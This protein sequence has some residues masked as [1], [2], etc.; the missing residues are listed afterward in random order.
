M[1]RYEK[2]VSGAKPQELRTGTIRPASSNWPF[3]VRDDTDKRIPLSAQCYRVLVE[4][5]YATIE[6]VGTAEQE[7]PKERLPLRLSDS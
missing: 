6:Y 3:L 4:S 5:E 2:L 1:Q 7:L